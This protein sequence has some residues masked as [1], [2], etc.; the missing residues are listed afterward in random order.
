MEAGARAGAHAAPIRVVKNSIWLIAQPLLM[1]AISLFAIAYIARGLG[2][3]DYGRFVYALSFIT[4]FMPLT[5]LGLRLLTVRDIA[6]GRERPDLPDYVGRMLVLRFTL[7]IVGALL[8]IGVVSFVQRSAD[9]RHV[10]Y[11]ATAIILLQGLTTT[12]TD[13]FQAFETMRHVA[14]VQFVS[15]ML[16]TVLSVVAIFLGYGLTGL[17]ASYVI[18]NLVG[19]V[20]SLYYLYTKYTAPRMSVD[21]GFWKQSLIKAAPFFFPTLISQTGRQ[22][23]VV[24]MGGRLGPAPVGTYGA[25]STLMDKLNIIPDGVCT[26]LFPTLAATFKTSQEEAAALYRRFFGYFLILALPIAVGTSV[27]AR[28]MILLLYGEKYQGTPIVLSILVWGLFTSFFTQLQSWTAGAIHQERKVF[29]VPIASTVCY[30][31][32]M[33]ALVP[34][35]NETGLAISAVVPW[36]VMF[37]LFGRIIRRHLTRKQIDLRVVVKVLLAAAVMG[38]ATYRVRNL[39]IFVSIPVGAI[40]YAAMILA[41]RVVSPKEL[42]GLRDMIRKKRQKTPPSA[43]PSAG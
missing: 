30:L 41:L 4:M 23:G 39:S 1:N 19:T 32:A 25:A 35:H 38:A 13:V 7:A 27:L 16:L 31:I 37:V 10:V 40:T 8:A 9:T 33:F 2:K 14:Q 11:L 3:D 24:Y 17:M 26:A 6:T 42:A 21:F 12:V 43:E 22:L 15:G 20:L 36:A 28:P 29:F 5:N 34:G 18:G